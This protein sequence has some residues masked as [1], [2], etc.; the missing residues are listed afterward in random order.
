MTKVHKG[1]LIKEIYQGLTS[2]SPAL[3]YCGFRGASAVLFWLRLKSLVSVQQQKAKTKHDISKHV[4]W[5]VPQ[6][7]MLG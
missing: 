4:T 2:T 7:L 1:M 3:F 5:V 6:P